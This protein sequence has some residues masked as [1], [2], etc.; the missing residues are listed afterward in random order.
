PG[1]RVTLADH[2]KS[3]IGG[4]LV[5]VIAIVGIVGGIY[6]FSNIDRG[7]GGNLI[8]GMILG[9]KIEELDVLTYSPQRQY[10]I[11]QVLETLFENDYSGGQP[12]VISNLA[13]S[14][15]WNDNATE[16]T[17]VL[18]QNVRFHDGTVFN[19]A[20]V[21]WNFDR[22]YRL[23]NEIS[24]GWEY[25]FRLPDGR[26]IINETQVVD[27]YTVKFVLNEPFVPFVQLLTH[28][29]TGIM[30][31][32]STPANS[33]ID[34]LTGDLIGTGPFI[35]DGQELNVAITMSPN[36]NYWGEI[37]KIDNLILKYYS[38]A[39]TLWEA[40]LAQ[41]ISMLD[42]YSARSFFINNP[43]KE[44]EGLKSDTNFVVQEIVVPNFRYLS[45]D[46]KNINV[47][48]RKAISYAIN[49]SYM[50]EDININLSARARSPVPEGTLY[51][52]TTAFDVPYYNISMAR[53]ILK[54][55]GWLGT[56]GLTTNDNVSAGNEWEML[57][58]NDT[59]LERYN[60]SYWSGITEF[61]LTSILVQ[62]N[63]KQI[64]IK[65]ERVGNNHWGNDLAI[66]GWIVDY[67][68]PHNTASLF[69][70][71]N[72]F[73]SSTWEGD[74]LAQVNDSLL[75]QWI[76]E[77]VKETDPILRKQLY[78]QIQERLIEE[79]YPYVWTYAKTQIYVYV[80][81][82]KGWQSRPFKFLFKTVYFD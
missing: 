54:D 48:M 37:P 61:D 33:F 72:I 51:S 8:V 31:P 68:D 20:A 56:A 69:H 53:K 78:Y 24:H 63:L 32:T 59:P 29:A 2:K 64:G 62:D 3:L 79:L 16:F 38:N 46:Y 60:V 41:D 5:A 22:N 75:D 27:E 43:D 9:N 21:K 4:G 67:G 77:G 26:W 1:K 49:Y 18:R 12:Q 14:G 40:L 28:S 55:V 34:F 52:N 57:V 50:I 44:L 11:D 6:I 36:P 10:V 66:A 47:T 73:N 45:M 39:T 82:L 74:N 58:S 80:S 81:N 70:S 15:I 42:P 25:M 19:A 23:R 65:V 17:C 35:Y 13:T 71:G 30:S 76:E 7:G